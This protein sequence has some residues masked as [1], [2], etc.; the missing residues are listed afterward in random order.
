MGTFGIAK[1]SNVRKNVTQVFAYCLL[2]L[3]VTKSK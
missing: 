3:T 2:V 1:D